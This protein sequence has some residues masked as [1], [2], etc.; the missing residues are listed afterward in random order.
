MHREVLERAPPAQPQPA[1]RDNGGN[2]SVGAQDFYTI[3]NER[4]LLTAATPINGSGQT[5]ALL[6]ET[7]IVPN[8]VTVFRTTFGVTPATPALTIAH[9]SP[10]VACTAPGITDGDEE[11]EAVLDT[12]WAGAVAPSATLLFMAC[13]STNSTQ[14]H[15]PLRRSRHRRQPRL[16]HE[17]QLRR[18]RN[19]RSSSLGAFMTEL[20]EQAAAQGQTVVVSSGDSGSDT[21][22]DGQSIATHGLNVN[23]LASTAYNISAG[24]TDFQ[25]SYNQGLDPIHRLRDPSAYWS[26]SEGPGRLTAKELHRRNHLER[27]L[28]LQPPQLHTKRK[29][30]RPQRSA[31]TPLKTPTTS[32]PSPP[33]AEPA[34][35]TPALAGRPTPSSASPPPPP[36]PTASSPTSPSSPPTTS[37]DTPSPSTNP[38]APPPSDQAGGTSFVAPQLAGVFA[39]IAQKTNSRLGLAN[40]QLY[41]LAGSQFGTTSFLG[42]QCNGSGASGT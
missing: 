16:R 29:A 18:H 40:V 2:Q 33:A 30:P 7:D 14:R 24:G 19:R 34:S 17:P 4:P 42:S 1:Y 36:T 23:V 35:S 6:E 37:G 20:W 38:T 41:N 15:L 32:P 31:T 28:R 5:I 27:L 26:G 10:S 25:D 22:S 3:Y 12:E 21:A 8:D 39:L 13:A 9:G 11:G